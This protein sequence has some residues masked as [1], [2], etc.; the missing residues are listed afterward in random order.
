MDGWAEGWK[1]RQIDIIIKASEMAQW[2]QRCFPPNLKT[3][4]WF[5]GPT[6]GRR[7]D[8]QG[9]FPHLTLPQSSIKCDENLAMCS[10]LLC[11]SYALPKPSREG[12]GKDTTTAWVY[13]GG[14]GSPRR[15]CTSV[16]D[17]VPSLCK[18]LDWISSTAK[19]RGCGSL[20]NKNKLSIQC[21]LSVFIVRHCLHWPVK[22]FRWA[23]AQVF[24]GTQVLWSP[25]QFFVLCFA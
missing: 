8:P 6:C 15:Q 2:V 3:W 20:R 21:R 10:K 1:D 18:V 9:W 22:T 19:W 24:S 11:N 23:T 17:F 16:V 4:V 5:S 12:T 7:S 13:L 14:K 25:E